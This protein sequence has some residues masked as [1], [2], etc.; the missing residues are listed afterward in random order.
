MLGKGAM[1]GG[2]RNTRQPTGNAPLQ[3]TE[4]QQPDQSD[5]SSPQG[6]FR[7]AAAAVRIHPAWVAVDAS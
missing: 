6:K 1:Q 2:E 7:F 4:G 3:V 5:Q